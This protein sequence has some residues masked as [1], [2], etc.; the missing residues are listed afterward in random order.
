MRAKH[1]VTAASIL[2]MPAM[3]LAHPG[4]SGGHDLAAGIAHPLSG[5]DHIA[6]MLAVGLWAAQL[7]GK[8]TW[9]LPLAFLAL[10]LA[11]GGLAM[12]GL[13]LPMLEAV[14][15]A[16][17]IVLALFAVLRTRLAGLSM[18]LAAAFAVCHGY[19]HIA[20]LPAGAAIAPY[21]AGL[22]TGS[23]IVLAA[24]VVIGAALPRRAGHPA[25]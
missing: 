23:A 2:A 16:S 24:G 10:M 1:L 3:V 8:T 15:F 9:H 11:G 12:T 14:L 17:V 5:W 13:P 7:G 6:A 19:A 22:L 21:L 4:H 18:T 25:W 20:E